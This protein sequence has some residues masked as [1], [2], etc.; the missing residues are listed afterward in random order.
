[1]QWLDDKRLT[2][3][4]ATPQVSTNV[5]NTLSNPTANNV[6]VNTA[7]KNLAKNNAQFVAA[8][9]QTPEADIIKMKTDLQKKKTQ[10]NQPVN[11]NAL[12]TLPGIQS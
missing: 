12:T 1:M 8:I 10:P 4:A 7:A 9:L 11:M 5:I 6:D 3:I 2:E